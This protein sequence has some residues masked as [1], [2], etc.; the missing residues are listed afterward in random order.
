MYPF[1]KLLHENDL[2]KVP[3]K[4]TSPYIDHSKIPETR[5]T[6]EIKATP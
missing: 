1:C 4:G 6:F 5:G 3:E 2:R